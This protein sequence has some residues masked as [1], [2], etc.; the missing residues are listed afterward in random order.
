[1]RGI[2][3]SLAII[4][5][6]NYIM[7]YVISVEG[8][9]ACGKSTLL[10]KI[11][12][13]A[14]EKNIRIKVLKE[15]IDEWNK[16]TL[17]GKSILELFYE[18]PKKYGFEFQFLVYMSLYDAIKVQQEDC[19][20]LICERSL[21]SNIHIFAQMLYD[22]GWI[23]STQFSI[24]RYMNK[25]FSI[26]TDKRVYLSTPFS[27]CFC[28]VKIRNRKGEENISGDYLKTLQRY[29]RNFFERFPYNALLETEADINDFISNLFSNY[30]EQKK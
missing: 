10:D 14:T 29:H 4:S 7:V 21:E 25:T 9:I 26:K 23:T 2:Y 11:Q 8:N 12:T 28:R 13:I 24:L 3:F 5:K 16:I 1:M 19:D 15:P 27:I 22:K 6:V 18:D 17:D 30:D 20:I